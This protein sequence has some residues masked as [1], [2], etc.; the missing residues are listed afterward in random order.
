[1]SLDSAS[2]MGSLS[3]PGGMFPRRSMTMRAPSTAA[4]DSHFQPVAVYLYS[5]NPESFD[6]RVD[7][8]FHKRAT[9]EE[10]IEKVLQQKEGMLFSLITPFALQI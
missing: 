7:V 4:D 8:D 2:S 6:D 5:F 3:A 10:L 9:T 1:M